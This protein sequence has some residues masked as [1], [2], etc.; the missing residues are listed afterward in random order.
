MLAEA[1]IEPVDD[2]PDAAD[3]PDP[4]EDGRRGARPHGRASSSTAASAR[5]WA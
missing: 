1:E 3:L 5:A 4:S 2:V